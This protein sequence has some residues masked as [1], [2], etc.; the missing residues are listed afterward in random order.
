MIKFVKTL[1]AETNLQFNSIFKTSKT[2][3]ETLLHITISQK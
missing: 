3:K 1:L 2:L